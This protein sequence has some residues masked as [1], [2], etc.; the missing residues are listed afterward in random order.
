[1]K[2][3]PLR[4]SRHLLVVAAFGFALLA[5]PMFA[6]LAHAFTFEGQGNSGSAGTRNFS[7]P[8]Q[9]ATDP[10]RQVSRFGSGDKSTIQQ[11]DTTIQFGVQGPQGSFEQRYNPSRLFD[12]LGGP[13][14]PR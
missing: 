11:G 1:M 12:P 10:D 4:Q 6:S 13:G 5:A 3:L 14:A 7:D 9:L 8:G 2:H